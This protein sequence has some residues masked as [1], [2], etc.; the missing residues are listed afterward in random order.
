MYS[1]S[2]LTQIVLIDI[3]YFVL[4][5]TISSDKGASVL[6]KYFNTNWNIALQDRLE[7]SKAEIRRG[8]HLQ[9]PNLIISAGEPFDASI[10]R[11]S[12]HEASREHFHRKLSEFMRQRGESKS[13]WPVDF[14]R[15]SNCL[16]SNYFFKASRLVW[17]L[18]ASN[19]FWRNRKSK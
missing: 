6:V 18:Y 14:V 13:T 3:F 2:Y 19:Q 16:H 15:N 5:V 17:P 12:I 7:V 1:I 4:W 10:R 9:I 8:S 11:E